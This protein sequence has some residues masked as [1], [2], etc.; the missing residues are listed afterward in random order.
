MQAKQ[1][2]YA[3]AGRQEGP[4]DEETLVRLF[5]TGQ[6]GVGTLV[7]NQELTGW[8]KAST[9]PG[10]VPPMAPGLPEPNHYPEPTCVSYAGFWKRVAASLIDGIICAIAGGMAGGILAV[11]GAG[12]VA[13]L[14][15]LLIGWLYSALMESSPSQATFGKMALGI[16]V[17]DLNG[18]RISF[19]RA[20][21][22][23]FGKILSGITL[24]I[25]YLMVAFTERKQGLH[26]MVAS[27]LV[28]DK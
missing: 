13:P 22:R 5:Q 24:C 7:W 15:G 10:L 25:G 27:T 8:V 4:V 19:G 23:H 11:I 9:I 3:V 18:E 16:V 21:G 14:A 28:I 17:T 26:D 1:W 6:L 20:T 12:R 2:Y